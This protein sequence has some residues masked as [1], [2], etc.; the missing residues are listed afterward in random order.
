MQKRLNLRIFTDEVLHLFAKYH[1][2]DKETY[3]K[4]LN[5]VMTSAPT[6][7]TI[8]ASPKSNIYKTN[9][10]QE[11]RN[12]LEKLV[13]KTV[14][15]HDGVPDCLTVPVTGPHDIG[16]PLQKCNTFS[17]KTHCL[18][19]L[20]GKG[21][22]EAILRGSHIFA[23]GVLGASLGVRHGDTVSVIVDINGI[24][25]RGV[26]VKSL[27]D[28]IFS[29]G[30]FIH[31][32]NGTLTMSRDE[33]FAQNAR[34]IAIELTKCIFETISFQFQSPTF[35]FFPQNLPSMMVAYLLDPQP[36]DNIIDVCASPGGKSTHIASLMIERANGAPVTG[37]V[38]SCDRS[39]NKVD[40]MQELVTSLGLENIIDCIV[41]D[42]TKDS[43]QNVVYDR[44][45]CDV[46]C[47]GLGQRPSLGHTDYSLTTLEQTAHYQRKI[48]KKAVCLVKNG[49]VLVYSTCT[50]SPLEN[51]EN[52]MWLLTEFNG[53]NGKEKLEL[54]T[55]SL[56]CD[57]TKYS[58]PG[59]LSI[60]GEDQAAKVLR[61]DPLRDHHSI[62]FFA[63][64]FIKTNA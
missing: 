54:V 5:D 61:F 28:E 9:W 7:S 53:E 29:T 16:E 25:K 4:N 49:G 23:P 47:S 30:S 48:L 55:P 58:S 18:V 12:E 52:V 6:L 50:I 21:C 46:P 63:A 44:V 36:S 57:Y 14:T 40:K 39:K 11:A 35:H 10:I 64:K 15:I 41:R 51:E 2:G 17:H 13:G 26:K 3:I 43:K 32:A 22:G 24:T 34:G 42:G 27:E 56:P 8:R 45:L 19:V 31:V 1:S 62:G 38:T 60:L 33:I 20:V 59:L 37:K